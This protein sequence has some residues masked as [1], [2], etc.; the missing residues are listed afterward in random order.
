[1]MARAH[2]GAGAERELKFLADR[3]TFRAAVA[4][5]LLGGAGEVP[6]WRRLKSVY[7]DTEDGDLMRNGVT[8]RVRRTKG[9][10]IM[11]LKRAAESTR[12]FFDRDELEMESPSAEPDLALFGE[13][14]SRKIEEIFGDKPLAAKFGSDIRRA[15]RTVEV[16]G[17]TIEVALD[18]GFLFAGERLEPV[19]EIEL[20]LKSGESTALI[21]LGFS[22]VDA[23]DVKLCVRSKAERAAQLMSAEPPEPAR[24]QPPEFAP[25][26][27]INE[28]IGVL[29]RNCLSQ[30]LG[31]LPALESGDAVEAVH[32]M[33]VSMRLRSALGLFNRLFPPAPSSTPCGAKRSGSPPSW[34][35]RATGTGSSTWFAPA[36]SR[37]SAMSPGSTGFSPRLRPRPT[38][39]TPPCR[40]SSAAGRR[41]FRAFAR[42]PRGRARLA[43]CG[44][45]GSSPLARRSRS[46][47]SPRQASI[48]STASCASEGGIFAR[49]RRRRGTRC[50]SP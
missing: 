46:P 11:G 36:L 1:M 20:E 22:L 32:Q 26:T 8:L 34:G 4:L 41:A 50:A 38:P 5:P 33:R 24:A 13:A 37:T 21:D 48:G 18:Q 40:S 27:P 29:L 30:F 39:A 45:E 25:D 15:S 12:G 28:A 43:K 6:E 47:G 2:E 14:I 49:S 31:N 7:F 44:R 3:K 35:R 9:A 23:L 10:T 16:G 42:A 17:A 19:H